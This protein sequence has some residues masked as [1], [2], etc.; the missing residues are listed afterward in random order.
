MVAYSPRRGFLTGAVKDTGKL[1]A[2]DFRRTV[3]RFQKSFDKNLQVVAQLERLAGREEVQPS[4]IA[5]AWLLAQGEDIIPIP[6]TKRRTYL[7][8][9]AASVDVKLTRR[10]WHRIDPI[11]QRCPATATPRSVMFTNM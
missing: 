6:G 10:D 11:M 3:P 9:N 7:E 1:S 2:G 8:E 5:L 4:Q